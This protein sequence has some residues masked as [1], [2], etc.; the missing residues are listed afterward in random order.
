[1]INFKVTTVNQTDNKGSFVLEPLQAGFGHTVG[2]CLRRVMLASLEGAAITSVKIA[3]A[4][5]QFSVLPGVSEDVIEI[6]L[7]LKKVRAKLYSDKPVRMILTATG[8]TEVKASDIDTQGNGEIIN[9]DLHLAS[10]TDAKTKLSI[11]LTA[12]K[13]VGFMSADERKTNEIGTLAVDAIFSP[14]WF[15]NYSVDPTRVGR[16]T[17]FERLSLE[18]STDGTIKPEEALSSAARLLSSYF[19]Q[20]FDPTLDEEILADTSPITDDVLRMSVEELDLP[21]RISNALKAIDIDSI[22]SLLTTP[23]S[24]LMK[25][26]NLGAKSLNLISEKLSERSLSLSEA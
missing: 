4:S 3:G 22:E 14:V 7:N 11:E 21:V 24:T 18:V 19:K 12:E 23:R 16:K 17:D 15:V 9:T 10:L 26:K 13:G 8:K 2:N 6:I 1:M 25:A 5:H 20:I